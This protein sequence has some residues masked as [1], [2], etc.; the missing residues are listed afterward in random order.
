MFAEQMP[1]GGQLHRH[2]SSLL[3][4]FFSCWTS[5]WGH[6]GGGKKTLKPNKNIVLDADLLGCWVNEVW[7]AHGGPSVSQ[8]E[9]LNLLPQPWVFVLCSQANLWPSF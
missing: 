2:T 6:N 8:E 9:G 4:T 1:L 3:R 5:I 7:P